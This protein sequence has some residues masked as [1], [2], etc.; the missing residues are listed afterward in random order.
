MWTTIQYIQLFRIRLYVVSIH[1][2][3]K[4]KF[5][6]TFVPTIQSIIHFG[7]LK[8]L[9]YLMRAWEGWWFEWLQIFFPV[10][11]W[12]SHKCFVKFLLIFDCKSTFQLIYVIYIL[13][14]FN[15]IS[16]VIP[17]PYDVLGLFLQIF[18]VGKLYHVK[19]YYVDILNLLL[20]S[21]NSVIH[22][23][24]TK[25]VITIYLLCVT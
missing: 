19:L 2:V 3:I 6:H 9:L 16:M 21:N 15:H 24:Y 5:L 13:F 7:L 14:G 22:K 18:P 11:T 25:L 17:Y 23:M 4:D 10:S 20:M 8:I 12:T 1:L